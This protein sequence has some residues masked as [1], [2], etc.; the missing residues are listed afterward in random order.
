RCTMISA[1]G[2]D[3]TPFLRCHERGRSSLLQPDDGRHH[4]PRPSHVGY[5][6]FSPALDRTNP[7]NHLPSPRHPRCQDEQPP[8]QPPRESLWKT[9]PSPPTRP[10]SSSS[11]SSAKAS[12][13]RSSAG[14]TSP[15]AAPGRAASGC[16]T[17]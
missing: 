17:D 2:T 5:A 1:P 16:W 13:G 12:R 7:E 3:V 6:T 9:P 10:S 8:P 11:P 14:A 4:S 15:T